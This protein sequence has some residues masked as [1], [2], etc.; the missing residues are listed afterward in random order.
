[1]RN[2]EEGVELLGKEK[3]SG[4]LVRAKRKLAFA[5]L[6]KGAVGS[7]RSELVTA[8]RIATELGLHDQITPTM[9]WAE[10]ISRKA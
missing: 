2:L 1:M 4:F 8:F 10:R 6:A 3:P 7:A 5:Y 9:R